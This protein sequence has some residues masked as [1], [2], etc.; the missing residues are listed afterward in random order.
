MLTLTGIM[1]A[2]NMQSDCIHN[3]QQEKINLNPTLPTIV[4]QERIGQIQQQIDYH[5]R[6]RDGL[7]KDWRIVV[8]LSKDQWTAQGQDYGRR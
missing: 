8:R 6:I 5:T 2:V 7:F 4:L 1:L 3:L